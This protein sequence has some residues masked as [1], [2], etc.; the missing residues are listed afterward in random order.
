MPSPVLRIHPRDNLLVALEDLAEGDRVEVDGREI[1]LPGAVPAKHKFALEPLDVGALATMYGVTVGRATKPVARG[2]RLTTDNLIHAAAEFR[3]NG[4][5]HSWQPPDVSKVTGR[6]FLGYPRSDGRVGTKN[7][8]LI[9]P[10]VFCENQNLLVLREAFL[11]ELGYNTGEK[12]RS[13]VRSLVELYRQ[14]QSAEEIERA[15]G[16]AKLEQ[17]KSEVVF[18]N[19]DGIKFLL[20]NLGCGG[21]WEDSETLCGLL[22]SYI[23]HPNVAGATLMG[24]GCQKAQGDWVKSH[25]DKLNPAF[26]KP[27]YHFEQ[28][29]H[30]TEERFL[31]SAINQTFIGMMEANRATREPAPLDKLTFGVEC[32]GSDGFSGISANPCIGRVSDLLVALGGTVILSEFPE[33]HGAEQDILDRCADQATADRFIELMNDY[34]SRAEAL[35]VG[36]EANPTHGNIVDGLITGA[37]KSVGA[38]KKGGSSTVVDVQDY[39][40]HVTRQGLNLLCTPGGDVES[41][42]ALA[43]AGAN[44]ILFSTGLG[45]PT[46]NP[47]TPVVKIS[48]NS[49]VC[50]RITDMIDFDAG[51]ILTGKQTL[52]EAADA[53]LE[54]CLRIASGEETCNADLLGQDDFIPWKRGISL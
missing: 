39:P 23:N 40:G 34:S 38:A 30:A 12:Y 11:N 43:G 51:T 19:V 33:L 37:I 22:A 53:L 50:E 1:E 36:L 20:H 3:Y 48:S 15:L 47:I 26:D 25:L 35:G 6:T 31:Q 52:E 13:H 17:K 41:T 42:T 54:Q 5:A 7:Y 10:L 9:I 18:E 2:G 16:N 45:T 21:M 49:A 4:H 14:G 44:M 24:L 46:G 32:G 27:L 28:Q 8:W 29:Q